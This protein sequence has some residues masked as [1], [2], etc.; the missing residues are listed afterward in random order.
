[1]FKAKAIRALP[2]T[3]TQLLGR[4]ITMIAY[5]DKP[6]DDGVSFQ[7][8][9]KDSGG[10]DFNNIDGATSWMYEIKSVTA[11][12]VGKYKCS[13]TFTDNTT[14]DTDE[15][16]VFAPV[17]PVA[18]IDRDKEHT[19]SLLNT[20]MCYQ[21]YI[22]WDA[23]D[24]LLEIGKDITLDTNKKFI[25]KIAED[26]DLAHIYTMYQ[27]YGCLRMIDSRDGY[28][29]LLNDNTKYKDPNALVVV[30]KFKNFWGPNNP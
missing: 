24:R 14:S 10:A 23:L 27:R 8:K 13:V 3:S 5:R 11:G 4:P 15:I 25:A 12:D 26:K 7:W 30:G 28:T 29:Y 9:K 22:R 20:S 1:M 18:G 19:A 16:E 17:A 6:I 2:I 21:T